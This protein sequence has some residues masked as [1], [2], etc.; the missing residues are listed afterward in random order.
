MRLRYSLHKEPEIRVSNPKRDRRSEQ[1][2][3]LSAAND[4]LI[5]RTARPKG[6]D[7]SALWLSDRRSPTPALADTTFS[8]IVSP[9]SLN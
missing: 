8:Y 7:P 3:R 2:I 9:K 4:A 1:W 6:P 5:H